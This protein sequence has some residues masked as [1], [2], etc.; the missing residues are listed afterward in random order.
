MEQSA[1]PQG[2]IKNKGGWILKA[3]KIVE[4]IMYIGL[5]FLFVPFAYVVVLS[6]LHG[7]GCILQAFIKK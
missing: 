2:K 3:A 4:L 1:Q 6:C 5:I 7:D